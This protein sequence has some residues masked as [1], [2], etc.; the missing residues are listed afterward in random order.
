ML[1]KLLWQNV[2]KNV[3][4]LA[5]SAVLWPSIGD[6]F[7]SIDGANFGNLLMIISILLV[8]VCFANFAFTYKNSNINSSKIRALSHLATFL[9]LL[10]IALL[11]VAMCIGI[12]I[13]YPTVYGFILSLSILLY[14]SIVLYDFWDLCRTQE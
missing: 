5:I 7:R 4:V 13:I 14:I 12:G 11:L 8:T 2:W 6:S 9:F 10:I 1:K 3:L